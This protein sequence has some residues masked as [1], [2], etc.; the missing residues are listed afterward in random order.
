M[1]LFNG[2]ADSIGR[3][4]NLMLD[5]EIRIGVTGLS[6]GGKTALIT[7]L[8]N[9]ISSF[10]DVGTIERLPRFSAYESKKISYG[11]VARP[12]DLR[13]KAFPY[14]QAY[15]DLT[16]EPPVWPEPTSGISEIR[17]EL[18]YKNDDF[19]SLSDTKHLY[20][21]IWD[22][23]GEWLMDL[24]LLKM[25]YE[26]FSDQ[27]KK[28]V[29]AIQNVTGAGEWVKAGACLKGDGP[30]NENDLHQVVSLYTSWLKECKK[31]GFAMIVPGRFVLPGDLEGAPILEFVP[32]VWDKPEVHK[33]DSLYETLKERYHAYREKVVKKFYNNCFSRLDRQIILID[34]L[35]AL[36]GGRETFMD[37]NDTFDVLLE[38]FS[39][40][41][42]NLLSRLFSPKID[43]VIFAATKAD[44]ITID[45]HENLLNLLR[46]MVKQASA[47]VRADGS[48]CEFMILSAIRA[49]RCLYAEHEGRQV[50]VLATDYPEEPAF[51]PGSVPAKWSREGMEFFQQYFRMKDFRPPKL[52]FGD[53][54][55]HINI[56][57]LLN[58]LLKDKL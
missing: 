56:D 22:Y 36:M 14:Q 4:I 50:Q 16:S 11:G 41:S 9:M 34:C 17:L 6:R 51:F 31:Q 40:G 29:S 49:S 30:V 55:P 5:Q 37:I 13:V 28:R 27:I 58:Y 15:V 7:S 25:D 52:N 45:Q 24:M 57:A 43:K 20:I 42:S 48:N 26:E 33:S 19:L 39:Y 38:N 1:N 21:D 8:V 47:R 46:S 10:G 18:R 2:I 35:K 54:V 12:R 53:P 23:P 32:W 3:G 44:T